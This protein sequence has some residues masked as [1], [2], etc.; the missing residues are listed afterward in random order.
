MLNR[1]HF[2]LSTSLAATLPQFALAQRRGKTA[3]VLGMALEPPGLD[4]TTN[5]AAAVGEVV[6]YNI[7]ETLV[8]I[9]QDGSFSPLLAESWQA[10]PD[11]ST[12]TFT[13]RKGLTFHNGAPFNA[14]AVKFSLDRAGGEGSTSKDK[15]VFAAMSTQVVDDYTVV[16][17]NT[18]NYPGL[19]FILGQPTAVIVEP[20]SVETNGTNPVG[21]G[22]YKLERWVKGSSVVLTRWQDYKGM[23]Q[24]KLDQV[25]F[26]FISDA[27]A[28][29]AALLAGDV[30]AFPRVA[31]RIVPQ[32]RNNPRYQVILGGT[33][34]KTIVAINNKR[35]P[36]DDVRVRRAISAAIDR[37]VAIAGAADGFGTPI[38]SHYVPGAAGYVDTKGINP[39]NPDK[40]RALLQEAGVTL[41]LTLRM[42]LPPPS[43]ARQG[44]EVIA[45][46]LA[47]VGIRA[48]I[49][50]V[51]WAQ[52]IANIYGGARDYDLTIV[53]HVEPFDIVNYANPD[54]YFGYD[55]Q[56]FRNVFDAIQSEGDEA[57]RNA[58]LGQAQKM[59]ADDAVNAFLYQPVFPTV[60]QSGVQGLWTDSPLSCNELAA[61]SW[62]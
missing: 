59:L 35:K 53:S 31:T 47:A 8:K 2:I 44:G 61:L 7:M 6:L 5:A 34:A 33:R 36:L 51:E 45:A 14:H 55:S 56:A 49:Q 40:A 9:N 4:P 17:R 10:S 16:L 24:P 3:M 15:R 11:F 41:P 46:Q 54:Y 19:L 25:T 18:N 57:K 52:W 27:A 23:Q 30:D 43:Y 58:L 42:P 38:G 20:G 29:A 37:D 48:Q 1:R 50:N 28:Q 21:T 13:L 12:Y 32:F 22:P 39:F 60:A 26:R 62:R